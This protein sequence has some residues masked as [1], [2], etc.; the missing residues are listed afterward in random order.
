MTTRDSS[1]TLTWRKNM[2][3][4]IK[5][6]ISTKEENH[7]P[8]K[9]TSTLFC[10]LKLMGTRSKDQWRWSIQE[11]VDQ[12]KIPM[13]LKTHGEKRD[14]TSIISMLDQKYSNQSCAKRKISLIWAMGS[15]RF[16]PTTRRTRRWSCLSLV[17][18]GIEEVIDLKISLENHSENPHFSLKSCREI[19]K[20][21][22]F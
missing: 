16:L 15:K 9:R 3:C 22:D 5:Q 21:L 10:L 1:T 4:W 2:R 20:V 19:Y 8:D 6:L 13:V 18:V 14:K 7:F 17:M 11:E 12:L